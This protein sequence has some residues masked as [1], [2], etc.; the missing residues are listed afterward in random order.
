MGYSLW[1][2][3]E[4][5]VTE[6]AHTLLYNAAGSPATTTALLTSQS[7]S[8]VILKG[9]HSSYILLL[10]DYHTFKNPRL[11]QIVNFGII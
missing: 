3:R 4:S 11:G 9:Q 6:Q 10:L 1:C 8:L 2:C 7:P 5:D